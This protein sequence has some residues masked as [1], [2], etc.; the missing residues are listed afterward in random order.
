M[1]R[2]SFDA[3]WEVIHSTQEWGKYP[4]EHVIRFIARNFYS[5]KR[6]T[7]KILDFGCGGGS[8]TWYL[9][10]EGF[11]V[12]AF[13]GSES[14]VK[15][16]GERLSADNLYAHLEVA[17][18]LKLQYEQ[19]YFDAVIDNVSIYANRQE[20][21]VAMYE[22]IFDILKHGGKLLTV[23]F[24]KKTSGCRSGQ[25]IEKDTYINIEE[26]VLANRGTQHLWV[27]EELEETL[28][29]IGFQDIKHDIIL[30]TDNGNQVEQYVVMGM[31]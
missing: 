9:A 27:L 12:Y 6:N 22:E 2:K 21:I 30:Y 15:K 31:K 17:D 29:R 8:H 26:G 18:A 19:D 25:E 16:T 5:E 14:A 11:D 13:D 1:D 7:I 4:S 23:C 10:R 24:G 3:E 28:R 20:N